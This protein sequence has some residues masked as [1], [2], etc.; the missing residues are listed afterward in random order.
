MH[1]SLCL[2]FMFPTHFEFGRKVHKINKTNKKIYMN[3]II[4]ASV[5]TTFRL[6]CLCQVK[7]VLMG[8]WDDLSYIPMAQNQS[9]LVNF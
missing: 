4:S 5:F 3:S 9:L 7:L 1:A 2:G 8:S 6:G